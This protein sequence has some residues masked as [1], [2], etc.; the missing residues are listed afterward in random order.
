MDNLEAMNTR[1]MSSDGYILEWIF[2][3]M[4]FKSNDYRLIS[5]DNSWNYGQFIVYSNVF[6]NNN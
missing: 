2:C 1:C 5:F 3:K 4:K 6:K